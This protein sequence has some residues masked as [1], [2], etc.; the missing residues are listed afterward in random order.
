MNGNRA[1]TTP[2]PSF[3]KMAAFLGWV[4]ADAEVRCFSRSLSLLIGIMVLVALLLPSAW[5]EQLGPFSKLIAAVADHVPAIH[6]AAAVSPIAEIVRGFLGIGYALIPIAS[7]GCFLC[8]PIGATFEAISNR[9]AKKSISGLLFLY[10]LSLPALVLM[11]W[12][13]WELPGSRSLELTPTRGQMFF[14]IM[15]SSR[16][17]LAIFGPLFIATVAGLIYGVL[18]SVIAP[19]YSVLIKLMRGVK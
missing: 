17:G 12:L 2:H 3:V 6:K 1:P 7:I 18:A 10:L 19:L 16:F 11:C 14:S 15:V 4:S 9:L 5:A 8:R 13:V